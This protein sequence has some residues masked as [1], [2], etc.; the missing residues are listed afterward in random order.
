M[1]AP[2]WHLGVAP[3][4]MRDPLAQALGVVPGGILRY[5]CLDV[6]K[7]TGHLCPTVVGAFLGT[8][9]AL[10]MLYP[11]ELPVRGDIAVSFRDE[12]DAGVT[13]VIGAVA[14]LITGAAA[15]EGFK[16]LAGRHARRGLL[17]FGQPQ[18]GELRFMRIDSGR[19]IEVGWRMPAMP[20]RLEELLGRMRLGAPDAWSSPELTRHWREWVVAAAGPSDDPV[21][22][23]ASGCSA[24]TALPPAPGRS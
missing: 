5:D 15:E 6:A 12:R 4:V 7:L 23:H 1:D 3:I 17:K 16:G 14:G 19:W 18:A 9:K 10:W 20:R 8:R 21:F 13:G 11:D 2:A 24:S 22:V